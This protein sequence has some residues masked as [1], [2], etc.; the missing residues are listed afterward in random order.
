MVCYSRPT[1]YSYVPNFVSIG[2]FCRPV[3][4]KN[5]KCC[6]FCISAFCD[7]ASCQQSEKVEHECTTTN[8]P[9]YNG[10]KIASVLQCF[11]GEIMRTNSDVQKCDEQTDKKLNVFGR[12]RR[13]VKSE[14]HQ[15]WHGDR[16]P[17]AS[18]CAS[19]TFRVRRT[20]SP[21][22][23]AENLGE[24]D[25]LNLTNNPSYPDSAAQRICICPCS[26]NCQSVAN[27]RSV[28][29]PFSKNLPY[30]HSRQTRLT[31]LQSHRTTQV[32]ICITS[33]LFNLLTALTLRLS[34]HLLVDLQPPP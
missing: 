29:L 31:H 27:F 34:S 22:G 19:K 15:T 17:R 7:V 11:L 12:P 28:P 32:H 33:S 2:L 13:R 20:V 25:P 10:V 5:R 16:G 8:L 30:L 24:P 23:D 4:P 6:R 3:P 1:V 9:L 18:S 26:H 21:L 14:P